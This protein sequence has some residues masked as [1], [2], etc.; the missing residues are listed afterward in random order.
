KSRMPGSGSQAAVFPGLPSSEEALDGGGDGFGLRLM[1]EMGD[2][3]P[4]PVEQIDDRGM[5]HQVRPAIL[6]GD[7]LVVDP[8]GE[9]DL[10]NLLRRAGQADEGRAEVADV[11]LHQPG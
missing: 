8:I 10:R 4:V 1:R 11:A 3:A 2:E 9:G 7:L 6:A 5:V